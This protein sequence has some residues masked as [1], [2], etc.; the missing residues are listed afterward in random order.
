[1]YINHSVEYLWSGK[2]SI[3]GRYYCEVETITSLTPEIQETSSRSFCLSVNLTF[4][5]LTNELLGQ[6]KKYLKMTPVQMNQKVPEVLESYL[7]LIIVLKSPFIYSSQ[8]VIKGTYFALFIGGPWLW[9]LFPM[10]STWCSLCLWLI[11]KKDQ[12]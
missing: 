12:L 2:C 11:K 3:N 10:V 8:R 6:K 4:W 9:K 7:N 1:M 5:K